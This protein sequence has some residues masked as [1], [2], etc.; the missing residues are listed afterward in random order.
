MP[1]KVVFE[2]QIEHLQILDENGKVD[3][4]IGVP[5]GLTNELLV[6]MYKE[7]L[8]FR[9]FDKK[10]LALQRTGQLGTYAS[11]IGQE[12]AQV[13]LGYAM[14]E[15]DWLVPSFRDQGLMMLRGVPGHKII[16]YWNGDE[17][18]SQYDEGVNC[19]PICVPVGSQLLH[20]AGLGKALSLRGEDAACVVCVGD[21]GTSEGDF[22]EAC[23][24]AGVFDC[25]TV[26][27][28]QNNQWAISVPRHR[29]SAAPTLAQKSIGYGLHGLQVDG[30]DVMAMYQAGKESLGRARKEKK[31]TILEA[32]TYRMEDHTT[33]DDASKYRPAEEL[34]LWSK[35]DP[36]RRL[37]LYLREQGCFDDALLE[38]MEKEVTARVAE[39]VA[40]R[41]ALE[42]PDPTDTF[43]YLYGEMP[44]HLVEQMEEMK[45]SL[46]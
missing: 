3:P 34:E 36:M 24:F 41:E 31:A 46:S 45:E 25:P 32:F 42:K 4:E 12:A 38:S 8:F 40:A 6:E 16:T 21:G 20:G 17:R 11:L 5:E 44:P 15:K 30:N 9:R 7:M 1:R 14:N 2:G 35:R 37:E 26:I 13:G 18:G 19:L 28:I 39:Q 27:L 10:A 43:R 33:A 29:Q 23:N 22:H